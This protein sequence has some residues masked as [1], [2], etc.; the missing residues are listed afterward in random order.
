VHTDDKSALVE[1]SRQLELDNV[2]DDKVLGS[3]SDNFDFLL[4]SFRSGSRESKP[5]MFIL[6][7]FDLFTKHKGQLLLYTLLNTIQTSS[8]PMCLIGL[9]CRLDVL[10]QLEKRVKSR[11]SHRQIY[12]FNNYTFDEYICLAKTVIVDFEL[13]KNTKEFNGILDTFFNDKTIVK[14]LV[15]QFDYDKSILALKRL[16]MLPASRLSD[17]PIGPSSL[18]MFKEEFI[19]SYQFN[20][21]DTK[22]ELLNDISILEL[23]VLVVIKQINELYVD[24]PFNFEL[25]F[26]EY[27]KFCNRK[28]IG[29]KYEKQVLLKVNALA[30]RK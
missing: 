16:F 15:G 28:N 20:N 10:D 1:I 23:T 27:M 7:E 14:L 12:L 5:L 18:N 21:T 24:E 19:K 25:V 8:S 13:V 11:F 9:T 6:D 4:R 26:S 30:P 2:I 22:Y 17:T 29:Q 3:F